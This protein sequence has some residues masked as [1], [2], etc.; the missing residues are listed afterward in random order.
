MRGKQARHHLRRVLYQQV[1]HW[2]GEPPLRELPQLLWDGRRGGHPAGGAEGEGRGAPH[3]EGEGEG[4]ADGN[5]VNREENIYGR[6]G[7]MTSDE[8]RTPCI[9]AR[10]TRVYGKKQIGDYC[11][12]SRGMH[13]AREAL[14]LRNGPPPADLKN[15]V[16]RHT[17]DND[18]TAPN[19]WVCTEHTTWS[20]HQENMMD[21]ELE[22]RKQRG[23][24]AS[25]RP[26][27][28]C[29]FQVTCPHCGKTGTKWPMSRWH[30]D[31][32]KMR[33]SL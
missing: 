32:C 2:L 16:C 6:R 27:A 8:E 13:H 14:T 26:D 19:G 12:A 23:R 15:P 11:S 9:P 29:K 22:V 24:I 25:A 28:P 30:F 20:T 33:A 1:R 3:A 5:Q 21:V 18:S 31:N 17:C 4:T 7:R 10:M